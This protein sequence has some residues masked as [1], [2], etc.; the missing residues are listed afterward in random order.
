[1]IQL[2]PQGDAGDILEV[3]LDRPRAN[4]LSPEMLS[5]I[6]DAVERASSEGARAIVLSGAEGM[7]SAGLD[8]PH[9]VTLDRASVGDAW[10]TFFGLMR[11][12]VESPIPIAAALT[13]HAPA[14]G[15]VLA[16]C[17]DWRVMAEGPFKIGLNEVQVGVRM[18]M[19]IFAAARHVV[20]TRQAERMCTTAKLFDADE[21][22]RMGLVD[23]LAP[24]GEV[25][26]RAVAWAEQMIALPTATLRKTRALCRRE[27]VRSFDI[28]DDEQLELFLDEWFDDECQAAMK[29]LVVRLE[30]KKKG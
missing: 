16:L 30:E 4:A 21:A 27:F 8:I 10:S 2:N 24:A 12:M 1:M 29:S 17:C 15:C 28:V 5:A 7:F 25:I 11:R 6:S 13:G 20:G 9:F 14:G 23:E 18:P 26:P 22:A 3:R 19:P